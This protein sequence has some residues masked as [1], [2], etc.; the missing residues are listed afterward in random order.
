MQIHFERTG[1][2]AGITLKTDVDSEKLPAREARTL[3]R[4]IE[5]ARLLDQPARAS[6][7][8]DQ[9]DQFQYEI[10]VSDAGRTRTI[11]TSDAAVSD[12]MRELIAW[13]TRAARKGV[14]GKS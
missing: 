3:N 9:P 11:Q 8:G 13:L 6:G 7:A 10:T 4:L 1:G 5:E 2:F 12:E 14:G